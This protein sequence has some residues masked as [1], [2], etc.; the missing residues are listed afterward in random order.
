[1]S[2]AS[3]T[4][5]IQATL[6]GEAVDGG[7]AL[8][9]V[10]DEYMRYLAVNR[11]A[12]EVLGYTRDELLGLRVSD[13]AVARDIDEVYAHMLKSAQASGVTPLRR[14]DGTLIPFSFWAKETTAAGMTYWVTIGFVHDPDRD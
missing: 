11:Y 7:P 6:I 10:A 2:S 14:R 13:I 5:L 3:A 8:V 1:M 12:C 4:E 9:F